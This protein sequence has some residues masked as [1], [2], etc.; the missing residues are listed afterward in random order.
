MHRILAIPVPLYMVCI[1]CTIDAGCRK[2]LISVI[3]LK[4]FVLSLSLESLLTSLP[5]IVECRD[6][7]EQK[8][9]SYSFQFGGVEKFCKLFNAGMIL[10]W[11]EMQKYPL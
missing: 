4:S 7:S 11:I 5:I 10:S 2:S 9:L 8:G 6:G 3:E 1:C